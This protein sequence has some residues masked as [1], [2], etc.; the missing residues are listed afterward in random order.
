M[1][2]KA[3]EDRPRSPWRGPAR[4]AQCPHERRSGACGE[5]LWT[6][7]GDR[8]T[9][10]HAA[11]PATRWRRSEGPL[12]S[13]RLCTVDDA[14]E[15]CVAEG[16]IADHLMPTSCTPTVMPSQRRDLLEIVDDRCDRGSLADHQ[17]GPRE[18]PSVITFGWNGRSQSPECARF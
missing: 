13:M 11:S 5:A 9:G 12:R 10:G 3:A 7:V 17:P 15:D 1:P 18:S 16:R 2:V 8:R 6:P 4:V 14:I